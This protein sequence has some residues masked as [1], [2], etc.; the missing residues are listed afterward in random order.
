[1]PVFISH[2]TV[3]NDLARRVSLRLRVW[4]G[5]ECYVDDM[6]DATQRLR[7]TPAITALIVRRLNACSNLLAIV[8]A[9]TVDS[10]W[11]PFEVGVARQAP[12]V[13]TTFTDQTD[14]RLPDFLLEWPRLRGESAV[15]EFAKLYNAQVR[16]L[17]AQVV[18]KHAMLADQ[19]DAVERFHRD[20]KARLGQ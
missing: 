20:L 8:T 9:N 10:W 15:D 13:I 19:L 18:E 2:R 16:S 11:V 1:M 6:D 17:T 7:G 3:D 4:H 12:R 5:I 14:D